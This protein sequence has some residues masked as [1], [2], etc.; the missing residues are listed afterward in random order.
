LKCSLFVK[1]CSVSARS[2]KVY[3]VAEFAQYFWV[4]S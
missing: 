4:D 3:R 1:F 2:L